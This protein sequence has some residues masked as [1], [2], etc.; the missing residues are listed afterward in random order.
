MT[1]SERALTIDAGGGRY[2]RRAGPVA[3]RRTAG[4]RGRPRG[5]RTGANWGRRNASSW[6]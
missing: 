2:S 1:S 4:G 5:Q 6:E 3:H